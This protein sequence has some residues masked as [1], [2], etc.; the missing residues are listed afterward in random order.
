MVNA[1]LGDKD[2]TE[3]LRQNYYGLKNIATADDSTKK[4]TLN[5]LKDLIA[6]QLDRDETP[7][8]NDG[9]LVLTLCA[10]VTFLDADGSTNTQ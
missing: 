1:G 9:F 3:A 6:C 8:P 5:Q 4:F 7:A 10:D 2:I